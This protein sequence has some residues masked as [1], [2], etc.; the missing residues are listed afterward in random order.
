ME[1]PLRQWLIVN[2][3]K[4]SIDVKL[5]LK[6]D[7]EMSMHVARIVESKNLVGL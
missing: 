6:C 3:L 1:F 5:Q 7:F 4:P 2:A